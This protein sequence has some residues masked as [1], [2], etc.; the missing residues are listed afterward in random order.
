MNKKHHCIRRMGQVRI[1]NLRECS[2]CMYSVDPLWRNCKFKSKSKE[3]IQIER[4]RIEFPLNRL[5]AP[6]SLTGSLWTELLSLDTIL[7]AL[8]L[9]ELTLCAFTIRIWWVALSCSWRTANDNINGS[10]CKKIY[11]KKIYSWKKTFF[12]ERNIWK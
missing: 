7:I 6:V 12:F 8:L 9:L 11:L 5:V 2:S 4:L 10:D 3:N 1:Y